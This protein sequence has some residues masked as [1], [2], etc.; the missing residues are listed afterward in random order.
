MSLESDAAQKKKTWKG[1]SPKQ[2]VRYFWDYYKWVIAIVIIVIALTIG[3]IEVIGN[4]MEK[5]I[6]TVAISGGNSGADSAVMATEFEEY[7]GGIKK[8]ENIKIMPLN[9]TN[10][11]DVTADYGAMMQLSAMTSAGELDVF[12]AD[13][14]NYKDYSG[15]DAFYNLTDVFDSEFLDAHAEQISKN[16]DA[17]IINASPLLDEL[18][19][20]K[21]ETYYLGII[22]N[23]PN[24][25]IAKQFAAFLLE[26][27][28]H[29][30]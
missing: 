29:T 14:T 11:Q 28:V 8:H 10:G 17:L 26:N 12:L 7:L 6:V 15:Q 30:N 23:A 5:T 13:E 3:A 16:G 21:N 27:E 20:D 24:A 19:Q 22:A 9:S 4:Q 18:T 1:L 2:K 25:E